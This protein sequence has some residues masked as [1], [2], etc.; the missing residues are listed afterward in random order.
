MPDKPVV[1][2][3]HKLPEDWIDRRLEDFKLILGHSKTRGIDKL[4]A[5]YLDQASGILCLLDDP[6][7]AEVINQ[8]K[9]LKVISNMAVGVDNIDVN[10]CTRLGIPVGHTPGV[11]TDGTAEL[12]IALLLAVCRKIGTASEDARQGHW[13]SWDP[14]GW[15]GVDLKGAT[16]GIVGLGKIGS[17]VAERLR[18]FGTRLIFANRSPL[19]DKEKQLNAIQVSLDE[20][21]TSSDII[22]LHVPLTDL[23]VNMIDAAA[24][25]KMKP[26]AVLINAARGQIV[27]TQALLEALK[28]GQIRAAGLDVT[29]PEPLPP[30]HALYK[31]ENC[32]ITPHIGSATYHT[33]KT[34]ADIAL[35]NLIAGIDGL[36]LPFCVNPEVYS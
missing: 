29:D 22:C 26:T 28:T 36:P 1:L 27:N 21:L 4:L 24:L 23:T 34:M 13:T 17:A 6:I 30:D 25:R 11:L 5:P 31:L 19:P 35:R 7:P 8:A 12:T 20:L 15:L 18:A 14:T 32:L 3:T 16:V 9:N 10:V 2:L 33:R